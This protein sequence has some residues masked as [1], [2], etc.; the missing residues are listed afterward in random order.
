MRI[1]V[2]EILARDDY[3]RMTE[4]L[5]SVTEEVAEGIR[6]KMDELDIINNTEFDNGE[7]GFGNVVVRSDSVRSNS[8]FTR[9][10][11]AIKRVDEKDGFVT[12]RSLE[13]IGDSYY[14]TG[15]FNAKIYGAS[16][17]EALAFLNVARQL[18]IGLGKVEQKQADEIQQAIDKYR[19][20]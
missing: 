20:K 9:E 6:K 19:N 17:N 3:K 7:I 15:D 14:F 4:N 2:N 12:W 18:I 11:L 1:N 13:D 10:F 5:K 8:G 16:N